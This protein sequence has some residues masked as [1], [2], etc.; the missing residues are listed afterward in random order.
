M[1]VGVG[2]AINAVRIPI[3]NTRRVVSMHLGTFEWNFC[4][5][6]GIF[7]CVD[8]IRLYACVRY[9]CKV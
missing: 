4:F 9:A 8:L 1:S 2:M 6:C 7:L 3:A 5:V